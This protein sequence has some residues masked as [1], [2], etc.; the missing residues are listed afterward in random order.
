[1]VGER[2]SGGA[3]NSC[4]GIESRSVVTPL[5]ATANL[6]IYLYQ[7]LRLRDTA[8]C[9]VLEKIIENKTI[10]DHRFVQAYVSLKNY[11]K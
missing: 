3:T 7:I 6:R 11:S 9:V 2:S 1:M 8:L 10:L 5:C 4:C